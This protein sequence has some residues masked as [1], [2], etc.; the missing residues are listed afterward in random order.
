MI[1][2]FLLQH[3]EDPGTSLL[4]LPAEQ[5]KNKRD[6]LG[7]YTDITYR[8]GYASQGISKLIDVPRHFGGRSP[9]S[10]DCVK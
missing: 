1:H 7:F 9:V 8:K 4:S 2:P 10:I 5:K 6:Q 3:K